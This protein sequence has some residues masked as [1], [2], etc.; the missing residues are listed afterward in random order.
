[1]GQFDGKVV[2][3]TGGSAGLGKATVEAFARD[4]AK[5]AF[6]ARREELGR[7]VEASIRASGGEVTFLRSDVTR[8]D[9]VK[10]L[11]ARTVEVYGRLDYAYNNAAS[12]PR[13]SLLADTSVEVFDESVSVFLR[14][15]FLCMKY[16]L[17]A[18]IAGGGGAIV[19][20]SSLASLSA[21]PT[22]G[23]YSACKAGVEA[24]TRVAAAE[25]VDKNIRVNS[26]CPGTFDT[27]MV[28]AGSAVMPQEVLD[29]I[30]SRIGVRRYGRPEELAH[31]VLF[32]CAPNASFITGINIVVDGGRLLT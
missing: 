8:E 21:W 5:V 9:E 7:E 17:Q 14:S 19:N 24:M 22:F 3:V 29:A 28:E 18:M 11:V 25:Y 2:L 13:M 32:L 1:M 6:S 10:A 31:A 23:V 20:C 26:V 16:E 27:P 12:A 4:G 30:R 15:V